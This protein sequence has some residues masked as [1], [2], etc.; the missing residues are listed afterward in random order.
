MVLDICSMIVKIKLSN[1]E[2]KEL[3]VLDICSMIVKLRLH[4]PNHCSN[5]R[6]I[7]THVLYVYIENETEVK[8]GRAVI[9]N[10]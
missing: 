2:F 1:S 4:K 7:L 8:E 3:T 6:H 9:R 5:A 10:G